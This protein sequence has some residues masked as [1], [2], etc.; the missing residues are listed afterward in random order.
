MRRTVSCAGSSQE[1]SG[2]DGVRGQ[3]GGKNED[4]CGGAAGE[5]EEKPGGFIAPG[6]EERNSVPLAVLQQ[7]QSFYC[8]AGESR[9]PHRASGL[10]L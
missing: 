9:L 3:R 2:S 5:D 7:R 1:C 8:A 6:E 10:Y 4:E